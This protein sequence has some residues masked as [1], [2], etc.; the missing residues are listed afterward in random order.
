MP[1]VHVGQ[2]VAVAA[3]HP[4]DGVAIRLGQSGIAQSR[5]HRCDALRRIEFLRPQPTRNGRLLS[6]SENGSSFTRTAES[7]MRST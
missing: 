3:S 1:V 6:Q 5:S 7:H 4:L 2:R